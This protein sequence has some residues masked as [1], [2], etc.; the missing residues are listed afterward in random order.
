MA[1]PPHARCAP[2]AL[3]TAPLDVSIRLAVR[4]R[5]RDGLFASIGVTGSILDHAIGPRSTRVLVGN[6]PTLMS[7]K[8]GRGRT[9]AA[10]LK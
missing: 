8:W 2:I 9:F 5:E 3:P 4:D 1:R 7:K 10:V 6:E